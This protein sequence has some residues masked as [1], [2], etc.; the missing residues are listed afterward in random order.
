MTEYHTVHD[1]R[2]IG[3]VMLGLPGVTDAYAIKQDDRVDRNVLELRVRRDDPTGPARVPPRVLRTLAAKDL[4]IHDQTPQ[5]D[6]FVLVC[7]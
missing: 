2:E 4:G 5:A 7:F 6:A 3:Q 1:L